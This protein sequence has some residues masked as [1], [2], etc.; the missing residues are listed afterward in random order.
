M[1][2]P[3]NGITADVIREM[4][5]P[6]HLST[7][8]LEGTFAALPPP[9]QDASASWR[10]ARIT[11]LLAEIAA[12]MPAD[13]AQARI[14][15]QILIVRELADTITRQ[16]YAPG[17]TVEQMCRLARTTAE[18]VRTAALQGRALERCQQKPVPFFGTVV[19]DAVDIPAL[20]AVWCS[21][22]RDQCPGTGPEGMPS[23]TC[24]GG[25]AAANAVPADEPAGEATPVAQD[26]RMR[27]AAAQAQPDLALAVVDA[28]RPVAVTPRP[29]TADRTAA[30]VQA[31]RDRSPDAAAGLG[32]DAG[33]I[34][35][36]VVTR[37]DQGP[38]WMLDV[39]RPA[40]GPRVGP[41]SRPGTGSEAAT[42]AASGSAA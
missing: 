14:A 33:A 25:E 24:P 19:A 41:A 20:D 17:V 28:E 35:E 6:Y 26:G 36:W 12:L 16:A 5:P 39:V 7:D 8:L 23:G 42:G 37:R 1:S 40:T 34:P 4:M 27:R 22:P 38:G 21:N 31:Q 18:L 13:P 15:T 9:P 3:S 11:R 32:R 2:L 29:P 10:Q 30:E